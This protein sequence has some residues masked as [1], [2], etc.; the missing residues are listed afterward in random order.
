ML[1][2]CISDFRHMPLWTG[3]PDLKD[4][5]RWRTGVK[6]VNPVKSCDDATGIS[7]IAEM[8]QKKGGKGN[9]DVGTRTKG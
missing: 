9:S 3:A 7:G 6:G 5:L 8:A 4:E 1:R 2:H